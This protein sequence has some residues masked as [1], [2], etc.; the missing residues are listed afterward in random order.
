MQLQMPHEKW[1]A[2]GRPLWQPL[3]GRWAA[4]VA[5]VGRPLGGRWAAVV[6]HA[7]LTHGPISPA[8]FKC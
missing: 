8:I 7:V 6:K 1:A 3:G 4:V 2:V 5:A